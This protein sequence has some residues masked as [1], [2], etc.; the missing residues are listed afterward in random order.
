M[1]DVMISI[2]GSRREGSGRF[3]AGHPKK[4][5]W[6]IGALQLAW[7]MWRTKVISDNVRCICT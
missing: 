1:N 6:M 5:T 4:G 7:E 3:L 2:L